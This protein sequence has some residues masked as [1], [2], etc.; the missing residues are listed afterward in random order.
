MNVKDCVAAVIFFACASTAHAD[1]DVA[2][3]ESRDHNDPT[4]RAFVDGVAIG[5]EWTN[6]TMAEKGLP[7]LYCQPDL[8]A[9]NTENTFAMLDDYIRSRKPSPGF[10][11]GL[12]LLGAYQRTFPCK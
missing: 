11:L 8:L 3:Y 2:T 1:M 6:S 9:L 12:V 5:I 10:S 7:T 4:V